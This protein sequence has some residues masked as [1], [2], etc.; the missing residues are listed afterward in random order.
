[1]LC[2]N[3]FPESRFTVTNN[4]DGLPLKL[5]ITLNVSVLY[6][7]STSVILPTIIPKL[8]I[9][10]KL[11]YKPKFP[12]HRLRVKPYIQLCFQQYIYYLQLHQGPN[13]NQNNT[14]DYHS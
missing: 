9:I 1:M 10:L 4:L 11:S 13:Q 12:K 2:I 3:L 8:Y 5:D 6:V 7:E 14:I